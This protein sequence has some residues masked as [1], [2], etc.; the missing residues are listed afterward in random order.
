MKKIT[1]QKLLNWAFVH[2]LPK[3]GGPDGIYS[4]RSAWG[5]MEHVGSLG[6]HIDL[7]R[8]RQDFPT[9]F[10][11]GSPH[12]DAILVGQAV[13]D[14]AKQKFD[15]T[16]ISFDMLPL[17]GWTEEVKALARPVFQEAFERYQERPNSARQQSLIALIISCAVMERKPEYALLSPE[18]QMSKRKGQ[19]C[20][21][22]KRKQIDSFGREIEVE[23][24]GLNL[25]SGRPYKNAY[26][27]QILVPSPANSFLNW[28][29]FHLWEKSLNFLQCQLDGKL[30][31]FQVV[32]K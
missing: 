14:L 25:K 12:P 8:G 15:L 17:S 20:W 26:T 22:T 9:C 24:G 28:F 4:P 16:D 30:H 6:V 23:V 29:D 31:D 10:E 11:Q 7:D 21:F 3:G 32:S 27:K 13:K 19:V 5:L 2:E 18:I 1:V